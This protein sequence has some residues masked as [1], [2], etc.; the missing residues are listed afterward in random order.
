MSHRCF[1]LHAVPQF[2]LF[3]SSCSWDRCPSQE[4]PQAHFKSSTAPGS[5]ETFQ[6]LSRAIRHT[7]H[8]HSYFSYTYPLISLLFLHSWCQPVTHKVL[9]VQD[10]SIRPCSP[11]MLAPRG[12]SLCYFRSRHKK[13]HIIGFSLL[14]T[15]QIYK[16]TTS[17]SKHDSRNEAFLQN[18]N[19]VCCILVQPE[20][21]T[22]FSK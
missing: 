7:H 22:T 18:N 8:L 13:S 5:G 14:Q 3:Q 10:Q 15:Q 6:S 1:A 12:S 11:C 19:G 4:N 17:K 2:C 16:L 21:H 9:R 20:K